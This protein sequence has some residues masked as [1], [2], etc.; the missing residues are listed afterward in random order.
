MTSDH[1]GLLIQ[2]VSVNTS[3]SVI[4]IC[5]AGVHILGTYLQILYLKSRD[6][7]YCSHTHLRWNF[8]G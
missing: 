6:W 3:T 1:T 4:K 2:V 8:W 5:N 7:T